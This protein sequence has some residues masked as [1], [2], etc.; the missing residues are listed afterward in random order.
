MD[1]EDFEMT[2]MPYDYKRHQ[3]FMTYYRTMTARGLSVK[4]VNEYLE[5]KHEQLSELE[6]IARQE[7]AKI[8][9]LMP[10]CPKCGT[11]MVLRP[12]F[13]PQGPRNRFGWRSCLECPSCAYEHYRKQTVE[14]VI[15]D[16]SRRREN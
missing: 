6:K 16:L 8:R 7:D 14:Q 10:P 4:D 13:L 11:R 3:D 1:I 5:K 9:S 2:M 12:V 15:L